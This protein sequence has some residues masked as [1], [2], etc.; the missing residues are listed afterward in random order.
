MS[1]YLNQIEQLVDLQKVDDSIHRV[2]MELADAPK[3]LEGLE[4]RFAVFQGQRDK[5]EEK[6]AHIQE[7]QKRIAFEIEEDV[8]RIKKSRNKLAMVQNQREHHAVMREMDNM[9]KQ[10]RSREEEKMVMAEEL[11]LQE[12]ALSEIDK[13]YLHLKAELE[14]KREGLQERLEKAQA[15]LEQFQAVRANTGS[16]VPQPVFQRYEFIRN[17]LDHPVIVPVRE[18]ICSGCNIAIPPQSF[19]ELQRGQQILSCPNCQ[20]LIYW[21]EHF[22]APEEEA[23]PAKPEIFIANPDA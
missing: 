15:K 7:Q 9:E 19:I 22:K 14:V 11:Q 5:V 21:C 10:N 8:L 18:G 20:R 17:R 2:I 12:D 23:T 1:V 4:E 3:E 16:E 13:D 6:I